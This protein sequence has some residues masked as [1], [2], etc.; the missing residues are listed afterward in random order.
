[1]CLPSPLQAAQATIELLLQVGK[2]LEVLNNG[3]STHYS[4]LTDLTAACLSKIRT[5]ESYGRGSLT[6]WV[7]ALDCSGLSGLLSTVWN[8]LN[9]EGF[10]FYCDGN[11]LG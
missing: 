5:C 1:M 6:V 2:A 11:E 4:E 9:S 3:E 10:S 7:K 8:Q